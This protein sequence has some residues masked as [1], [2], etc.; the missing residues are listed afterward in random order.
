[1]AG[2]NPA[3]I[4]SE[5]AQTFYSALG[6]R[7]ASVQGLSE[8]TRKEIVRALLDQCFRLGPRGL[9]AAVFLLAY[10]LSLDNVAT[11]SAY[12]AYA[13]KLENN[14]E[15]RELRLALMPLLERLKRSP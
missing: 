13:K 3:E 9:D 6:Q 4:R 7:L 14:R 8:T 2:I 15:L 12:S 10:G 11:H 1:M 5:N